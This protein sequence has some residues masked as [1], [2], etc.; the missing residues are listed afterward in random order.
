MDKQETSDPKPQV[1]VDDNRADTPPPVRKTTT[2]S[3]AS[4]NLQPY[5]ERT[6]Y[7][8]TPSLHL[9]RTHETG[10]GA[11]TGTEHQA[12]PDELS[13]KGEPSHQASPPPRPRSEV[14]IDLSRTETRS[15][16][17]ADD[18]DGSEQGSEE[19]GSF[20][21]DGSDEDP[22]PR[23]VFWRKL[24]RW[25]PLLD[26][27]FYTLIGYNHIN[28]IVSA[29]AIVLLSLMIA[30]CSSHLM[31]DVYILAFSY[32]AENGDIAI[33][34]AV[35]NPSLY[36]L[37]ANVSST[38]VLEVRVGYFGFCIASASR[39]AVGGWVCKRDATV[40]ASRID[41]AIDPL[42]LLAIAANFKDEVILSVIMIMATVLVFV[43]F[44]AL[45]TFPGWHE[46]MDAEG[47]IREVKPFPSNLVLQLVVGCHFIASLF[48]IVAVLWQHIASVAYAANTEIIYGGAVHARIGAAAVGM[49][50]GAVGA[51][52]LVT[53]SMTVMTL[54]LRMVY[55]LL[56]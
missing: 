5:A 23:H 46:E 54:S 3:V 34:N 33:P 35:V 37:V 18:D 40:L 52:V 56:E 49:G 26:R 14:T 41:T 38:G 21:A 16:A 32:R 13:E 4:E 6:S 10:T 43:G 53:V 39:D 24:K 45:G 55:H 2:A 29:I 15:D 36:D 48:L 30:G 20:L 28:M 12:Q 42:N 50:W 7:A 22:D 19:T 17:E 11:D 51:T 1:Q 8:S 31:R 9:Q 47:S 27:S 44:Y 25:I